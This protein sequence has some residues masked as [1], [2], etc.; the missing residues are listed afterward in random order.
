MEN[1]N[2]ED[3]EIKKIYKV[4]WETTWS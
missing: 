1:F 3:N 2:I 4:K